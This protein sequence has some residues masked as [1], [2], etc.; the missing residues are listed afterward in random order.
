MSQKHGHSDQRFSS[1]RTERER[2]RERESEVKKLHSNYAG[3]VTNQRRLSLS[4]H[5]L[6]GIRGQIRERPP[7]LERRGK[8]SGG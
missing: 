7:F 8:N 3:N 4:S 2:E 6:L 5:C 1:K